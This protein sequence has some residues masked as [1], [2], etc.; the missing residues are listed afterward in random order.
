MLDEKTKARFFAK[1]RR[2]KGVGPAAISRIVNGR[3]WRHAA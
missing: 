2:E 3:R 1:V